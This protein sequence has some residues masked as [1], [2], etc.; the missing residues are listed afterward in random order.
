M[1]TKEINNKRNKEK[2]KNKA[3]IKINKDNLITYFAIFILTLLFCQNF[4]QMHYSSDT[5]VL[6]NL[7]Y[8]KYP[9]KYFLLDGRLISTIICYLA[10]ILHIPIKA[11]IIGMDF[12]GIILI[13]T[14]I[15]IFSMLIIKIVDIK[16]V[17]LKILVIAASFVIILNQFA[18][19]YL[20]FPE[21]AIMCLGLLMCVIAT[22]LSFENCKHKYLKVFLVLLIAGLSY[23]GV[24]NIYPSLLI[25]VYIIREIS[26]KNDKAD[27]QSKKQ[28][29]KDLLKQAI[30]LAIV[31]L[32]CMAVM[33]ICQKALNTKQ[34]RM[35]HMINF[36]AVMWRGKTVSEY[37]D[38]LW[39]YSMHMLPHNFSTIVLIINSILFILLKPKKKTILE[40]IFLILLNFGMCVIPMYIFNTGIAGRVNVPLMMIWGETLLMLLIQSMQCNNQI[41]RKIVY[42]TII[43][44][45][46]V[47]NCFV[48]Q[49][50]T[51]HI[52]ANKVDETIGNIINKKLEEYETESGKKVTKFTF[53]YDLNPQQFEKNIKPMGSM[54]ERKFGC[55]WCIISAVDYYCNRNFIFTTL[56][57]EAYEKLPKFQDFTQFS[58]DLLTFYDDTMCLIVY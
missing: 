44:S 14:A 24:L 30:I 7:G 9:T 10:G 22:K 3:K 13:T 20:L 39:N 1:D 16:K 26:R 48:M 57:S 36:E 35:M 37:M 27:N 43:I 52:A 55:S 32:I 31:L 11:Y 5:Y 25:L 34:D 56:P 8:M 50:I 19:E 47:N 18:L 23:Q 12:I 21:S 4:L 40:Y 42:L 41:I 33:K 6:Y 49:N 29:F 53:L 58:E 28:I 45:F 17:S 46:I 2:S 15:Y 54:T 38:E 51:E